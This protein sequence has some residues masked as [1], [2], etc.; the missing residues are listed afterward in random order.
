MTTKELIKS[1][2][3]RMK[4]L[5][6]KAWYT[7]QDVS[8]KVGCPKVSYEK[9]ERGLNAAPVEIYEKVAALYGITLA[10]LWGLNEIAASGLNKDEE[11]V[12]QQFRI[13]DDIT[14]QCVLAIL[15]RKR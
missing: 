2:G 3:L 7:Q 12:L 10:E 1:T 8:D 11:H 6:Q 14:R 9:Y 13:V 5:R 15:D 4:E